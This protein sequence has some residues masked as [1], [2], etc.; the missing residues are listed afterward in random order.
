MIDVDFNDYFDNSDNNYY[1]SKFI[2]KILED[3]LDKGIDSINSDIDNCQIT[4][5]QKQ[6]REYL[7]RDSM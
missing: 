6:I 2:I 1:D 4:V 5:T 3:I 7:K